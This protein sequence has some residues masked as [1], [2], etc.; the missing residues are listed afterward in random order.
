MQHV[1]IDNSTGNRLHQLGV[2]DRVVVRGEIRIDDLRVTRVEQA[3]HLPDC[4]VRVPVRAVGIL[5]RRQVGLKDRPYYQYHRRLHY[6]VPD[7]RDPQRPQ[8]AVGLRDIHPAN[9]IRLIR[10]LLER[11]RQFTE[12]WLDTGRLDVLESHPV[13]PR[14]PVVRPAA[15]VGISKH[16]LAVQLVVQCVEPTARLVLRFGMERRLQLLNTRRS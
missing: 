4:I 10:L 13:N 5:L 15:I 16:I 14:C 1:P 9:R 3:M 6:P 8:L 7:R 2:R 11:L 12:P